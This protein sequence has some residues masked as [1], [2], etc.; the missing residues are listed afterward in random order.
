[1]KKTTYIKP[2]VTVRHIDMPL[3]QVPASQ[4][5]KD[6][7]INFAPESETTI[8]DESDFI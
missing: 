5:I 4:T 8:E 6:D 3:M 2:Q 7:T 1:M